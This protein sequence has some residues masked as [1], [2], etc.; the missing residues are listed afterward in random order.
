MRFILLDPSQFGGR[1]ITGRIQKIGQA[2]TLSYLTES[3]FAIRNGTGV[4]PDYCRTQNL[5]VLINTDQPVHLI[6]DT[7]CFNVTILST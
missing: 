3:F 6:R 1:K 4:T 7:D 5:A 2:L